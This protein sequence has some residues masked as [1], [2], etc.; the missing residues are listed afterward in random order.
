MPML[1]RPEGAIHYDVCDIVPPWVAPR[2]TILFLHGLAIDSDIWVTW[3]PAL[4]DRYRIVRM[5]LRGFGRS[6]VPAAGEAWSME[7]L[8]GDVRDVLAAGL[9]P[10]EERRILITGLRALDGRNDLDVL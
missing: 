3:L 5:D 8:A 9:A 4:A 1:E 10:D 2:E 7:A 6:F